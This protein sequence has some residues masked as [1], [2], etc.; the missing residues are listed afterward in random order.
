VI[1][2]VL[3]LAVVV[4]GMLVRFQRQPEQEA[5]RSQAPEVEILRVAPE[6]FQLAVKSQGTVRPV[7][8]T[9]LTPQVSGRII[10]IASNF[11]DGGF[12]EA[13]DLLI[14]ID[15]VDFEVA[16]AE[17]EAQLASARLALAREK[18]ASEQARVDWERRGR[19]GQPDPLVLRKPQLEQARANV[20]SAEARLRQARLNLARTEIRAPYRGRI[21]EAFVDIGQTVTASGTV[22]ATVYGL[23]AFEVNLPLSQAELARLD[24]PESF[25]N[26]AEISDAPRVQ[27]SAEAGDRR[28]S[29]EGKVARTSG[30]IDERSRLIE[31]VARVEDPYGLSKP[32]GQRPPLQVG[33]FVQAEILG[34]RVT[35]AFVLPQSAVGVDDF[36]YRVEAEPVLNLELRGQS[37]PLFKR[38]VMRRTPVDI[39]AD[40]GKAVIVTGGVQAGQLVSLT[41]VGF[42]FEGMQVDP[43]GVSEAEEGLGAIFGWLEWFL[44]T[45]ATPAA[46]EGARG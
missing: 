45:A 36:V 17:A 30:V 44:E 19:D 38:W 22:L 34:R 8:E 16:E 7:V 29:W 6:P 35:D 27:L 2:L 26:G 1:L 31:V 43:V 20:R 13:G 33:Q 14:Q 41:Q 10:E 23:D 42:F 18:A 5:V 12:F 9:N 15:P 32:G 25:Y 21:R 4:A 37:R 28:W 24:L 3:V 46:E 39:L 40:T 11:E